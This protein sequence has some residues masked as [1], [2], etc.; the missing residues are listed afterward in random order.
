M[1]ILW[2]QTTY[3]DGLGYIPG[4]PA[5]RIGRVEVTYW[6]PK[7]YVSGGISGGESGGTKIL[8]LQAHAIRMDRAT[9][10]ISLHFG[11]HV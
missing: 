6:W 2:F 9:R 5:L 1:R 8:D 10:R 7:S 3:R 4:W 11:W